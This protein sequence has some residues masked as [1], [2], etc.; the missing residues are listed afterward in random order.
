MANK[1]CSH[2]VEVFPENYLLPT[3]YGSLARNAG[4]GYS[5]LYLSRTN[6]SLS[7]KEDSTLEG[8]VQARAVNF[9]LE[10]QA[11]RESV[12]SLVDDWRACCRRP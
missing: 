12:A 10:P 2:L 6:G 7:R 1:K 11:I 5:Y 3:F 8:R 9:C 4:I